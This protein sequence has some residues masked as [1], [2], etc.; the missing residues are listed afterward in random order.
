[1]NQ[2]ITIYTTS[3]GSFAIRSSLAISSW[4]HMLY[5]SPGQVYA[6][7]KDLF[8]LDLDEGLSVALDEFADAAERIPLLEVTRTTIGSLPGEPYTL[9]RAIPV[10]IEQ[11]EA[12]DFVAEF[13]EANIAISG[14][15]YHEAFQNLI[16][17][18][19]NAFENF[20]TEE[21]RLGPEPTRQL[22][23]LRNYLKPQR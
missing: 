22:E 12:R 8:W 6:P 9:L 3:A 20:S 18:I 11:V 17:E 7:P 16:A 13:D 21:A 2:D 19:L 1:M 15:T 5:L 4:H 14:E 23:V 10:K